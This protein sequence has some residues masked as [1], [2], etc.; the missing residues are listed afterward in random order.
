MVKVGGGQTADY[1]ST[2]KPWP[3]TTTK[4][5]ARTKLVYLYR[6]LRIGA[7]TP[8][9]VQQQRQAWGGGAAKQLSEQ[10][11]AFFATASALG[12]VLRSLRSVVWC[13]G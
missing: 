10:R 6:G 9:T 2:T 11:A 4:T 3:A 12:S 7:S 5:P 8:Y 13:R 1:G